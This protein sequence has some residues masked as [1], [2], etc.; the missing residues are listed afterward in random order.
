LG[1]DVAVI[2]HYRIQK[3][4]ETTAPWSDVFCGAGLAAMFAWALASAEGG[5]E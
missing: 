2:D 5:L 4:A 1:I 3:Q